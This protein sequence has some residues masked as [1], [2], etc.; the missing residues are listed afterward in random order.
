MTASE[1]WTALAVSA[2]EGSDPRRTIVGSSPRRL[3]DLSYQHP[4][5]C[6]SNPAP[7]PISGTRGPSSSGPLTFSFSH[8]PRFFDSAGMSE[9]LEQLELHPFRMAAES[10]WGS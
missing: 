1:P 7:L 4:R 2:S 8:H 3:W 6:S 9:C 5:E 10:A